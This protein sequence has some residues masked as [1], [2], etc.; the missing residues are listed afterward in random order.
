MVAILVLR[1]KILR[2]MANITPLRTLPGATLA[3]TTTDHISLEEVRIRLDEILRFRLDPLLITVHQGGF[4]DPALTIQFIE[5]QLAYDQRQLDAEQHT[6]A[7]I[8][9][10]LAIYQQSAAPPTT[11]A[12]AGS[13]TAAS[14][15]KPSTQPG[16]EAVMPQL[17]DTFIDRLLNLTGR[18]ED[19]QF[20][21]KMADDYRR[22]V[23]AAIPLQR[24]VADDQTLLAE[25]T[26]HRSVSKVDTAAVRREIDSACA[27][28]RQS[29]ER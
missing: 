2:V 25:L 3:R 5:T 26:R 14:S 27:D 16:G 29:W 7:A 24:D 17:G 15:S 6:A 18:A 10:T 12:A 28:G 11:P 1:A 13:A 4:A 19:M 20:R 8:R 21:Q 22:A 23:N 9:E